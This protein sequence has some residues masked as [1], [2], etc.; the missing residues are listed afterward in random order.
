MRVLH[1]PT[2][3]GG[4]AW[5][6]SRAERKLGIE[7][8]LVIFKSNWLN[9]KYD[10]NLH[11]EKYYLPHNI[12]K[13]LLF[14][15]N[16]INHY[17]VFHFNFGRSIIDYPYLLDYFDLPIL[18]RKN[19]KIIMTFQGCDARV[20]T[21]CKDSFDISACIEC[22][23][24]WCGPKDDKKVNRLKKAESLTDQIFVLNPDLM[25]HFSNPKLMLYSSVDLDEW[26]SVKSAP[27][28]KIKILHAPSNRS[29]KGTKY[30]IDVCNSLNREGF[31]NELVLL[32]NIPHDQVKDYYLKSDI[33]ID[34]LLCGWYGG[35]A[36]EAMAME[37]PV[38]SYLRKDDLDK[39]VPFKDEIP[40]INSTKD[41]LY[42][43]LIPLIEKE[44]LR[45]KKGK[46]GRRYV[47]KYHDPNKIAKNLID[48]YYS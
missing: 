3:V 33:V 27:N 42:D 6:L 9:Y 16:A 15:R 8:D 7:S 39:F 32:E 25:Y 19:K 28:K 29:I 35:F 10:K 2:V 40:I 24:S 48:N 41:S 14:F 38:I 18:K 13:L 4:N 46:E 30:V 5:A 23:N 12:I 11:L 1:C 44:S 34:Q 26:K 21:Y 20:K 47:E 31:E 45:R 17:D 22:E 36:V 37:K 43:N